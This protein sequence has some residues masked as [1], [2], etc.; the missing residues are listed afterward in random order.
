MAFAHGLTNM[1]YLGV[2]PGKSGGLALL[3][4]DGSVATALAMPQ[5]ERDLLDVVADL[6][7]FSDPTDSGPVHA[8]L[9]RVSASPQMGVV[10]AFTFGRGYGALLMA[11]TAA[12]IPFDLVSPR[13]WQ[14]YMG[15]VYAGRAKQGGRDKNISKR[16][17]QQCWPMMKITHAIADALLLA[18]FCRRMHTTTSLRGQGVQVTRPQQ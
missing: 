16:R 12:R 8:A 1:M 14:P 4:Q 17:A 3:R 9:E 6:D 18:E 13:T 7:R 10:S 2:D 15:V 11:L 5:T